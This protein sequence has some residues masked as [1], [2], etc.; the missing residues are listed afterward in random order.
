M[1]GLL[2]CR[3]INDPK[4]I[5]SRSQDKSKNDKY[6]IVLEDKDLEKLVRLK[7]KEGREDVDDYMEKKLNDIID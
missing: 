4:K 2:T 3:K 5:L 7:L 6:I 1:L